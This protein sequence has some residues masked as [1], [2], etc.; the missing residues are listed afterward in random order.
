M[1]DELKP[2][3]ALTIAS[4]SGTTSLSTFLVFLK[5][6]SAT[7]AVTAPSSK[8]PMLEAEMPDW[9]EVLPLHEI[10]IRSNIIIATNNVF[11]TV[12]PLYELCTFNRNSLLYFTQNGRMYPTFMPVILNETRPIIL[13]PDYFYSFIFVHYP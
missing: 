11:F 7:A 8:F 5:A 4:T 13:S 12:S 10:G 9:D 6:S 3:M 2:L 1:A